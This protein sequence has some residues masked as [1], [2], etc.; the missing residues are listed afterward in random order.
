MDTNIPARP[1]NFVLPRAGGVSRRLGTDQS[2]YRHRPCMVERVATTGIPRR[3][4]PT[5]YLLLVNDWRR[6]RGGFELRHDSRFPIFRPSYRNRRERV[7]RHLRLWR[8]VDYR[9]SG[10][11]LPD[12][13]VAY[14]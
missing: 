9:V 4:R 1:P 11:F 5:R 14:A 6:H 8:H 10:R 3:P 2:S 13:L 12:F 7:P